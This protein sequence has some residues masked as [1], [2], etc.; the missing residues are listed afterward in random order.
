MIFQH[1]ALFEHLTV[2]DNLNYA[3]RRRHLDTGP[4]L[5]E[6]IEHCGI[7]QLME[8]RP[9]QLSGGERQRVALA[10]SL[11]NAP[12]L[13]ALDEPLASLDVK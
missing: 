11:C 7:K 3:Q 1:A 5:S 9:S 13:L 10:R 6:I 12:R 2:R 4:S 8:Q